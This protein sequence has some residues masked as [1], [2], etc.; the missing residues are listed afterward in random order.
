LIIRMLC[1]SPNAS[2]NI[3]VVGFSVHPTAEQRCDESG[4]VC[5]SS[6]V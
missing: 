5:C 3:S 6:D 1:N 2:R 4:S